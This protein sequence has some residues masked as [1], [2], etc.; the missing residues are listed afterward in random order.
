MNLLDP[1]YDLDD[2]LI[3][4]ASK[5]ITSDFP[6]LIIQAPSLVQS[7]GYECCPVETIQI[8]HTGAHHWILLSSLGREITIYDNL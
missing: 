5:L 2:F 6:Y 1:E 7:S 3:Y 8:T 4:Q